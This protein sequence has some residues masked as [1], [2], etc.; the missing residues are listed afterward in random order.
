MELENRRRAD[1]D[2]KERLKLLQQAYFT[3]AEDVAMSDVSGV[4][5]TSSAS[6][7]MDWDPIKLKLL[8]A[9]ADI[10]LV[11]AQELRERM[12]IVHTTEFPRMLSSM[13]PAF[14]TVLSNLVRPSPD[15][16]SVEHKV[17]N[18]VLEVLSR[19]PNNEVLRPHAAQILNIAMEVL[20]NDYEDNALLAC[21]IIFDL[22]KNYRQMPQEQVQPYLDFV[23][24]AYRN[25][26]NSIQN[27]FRFPAD[28]GVAQP[29][30]PAATQDEKTTTEKGAGEKTASPNSAGKFDCFTQSVEWNTI[31]TSS[32][33]CT[34]SRCFLSSLDRMSIDGNAT[35][36]AS[37][38]VSKDEY[39]APHYTHD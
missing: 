12:E 34:A 30:T 4:A 9:D 39:S 13:L 15:T 28:L 38:Q 14:S 18:S 3:M 31:H 27:S 22:H 32:S 33:T 20:L 24:E 10:S 23:L 36:S 7:A 17:R 25:L 8:D 26:P 1:N 11:A 2:E 5:S 6:V 35:V 21:R 29:E 37:S 16:T 19:L